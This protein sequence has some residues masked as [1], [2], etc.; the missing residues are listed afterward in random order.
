M[1]YPEAQ[2]RLQNVLDGSGSFTSFATQYV[3]A[4]SPVSDTFQVTPE[5]L[6]EF[7]VYLSGRQIQPTLAEWSDDRVWISSKLT[8]AI[9]T[10]A[11][12]VAKGDEV[13]AKIDVEIQAALKAIQEGRN[14]ALGEIR[15]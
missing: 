8:E 4:H 15:R 3:S 6:D 11:H 10:L 7:K 5:I 13:Q 9:V 1:I 14:I 12:G 2:T